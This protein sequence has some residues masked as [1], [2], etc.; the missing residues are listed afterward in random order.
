MLMFI[1]RLL[2]FLQSVRV[3]KELLDSAK[4]ATN[5]QAKKAIETVRCCQVFLLSPLS[6]YLIL[7]FVLSQPLS[8]SIPPFLLPYHCLFS[9]FPLLSLFLL[10]LLSFSSLFPLLFFLLLF[11]IY[12]SL[13]L[14][15]ILLYSSLFPLLF[16]AKKARS[17]RMK[18]DVT[19]DAPVISLLLQSG[20]SFMVD[21]GIL[22]LTNRCVCTPIY[23]TH[24]T[25]TR[26]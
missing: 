6:F 23:T 22:K 15:S 13:Y 12:P 24:V 3:N 5:E 8:F 20:T 1:K 4:E 7:F 10:F 2:L 25:L 21:L 11:S 18:L 16:Q 17:K 26:N 19:V 14:L 9:Y